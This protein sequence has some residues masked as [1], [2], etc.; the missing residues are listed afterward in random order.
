MQIVLTLLMAFILSFNVHASNEAREL[1][2]A[3]EVLLEIVDGEPVF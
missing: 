2:L 3:Q 1:R